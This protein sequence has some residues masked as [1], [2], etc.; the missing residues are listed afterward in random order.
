MPARL[1]VL[2]RPKSPKDL[3]RAKAADLSQKAESR[4]SAAQREASARAM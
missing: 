4:R 2:W 1:S 3:G